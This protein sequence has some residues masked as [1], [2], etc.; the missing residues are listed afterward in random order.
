MREKSLGVGMNKREK[1]KRGFNHGM[2]GEHGK[3]LG[4]MESGIV[5]ELLD[6]REMIG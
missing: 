5:K 2:H 3:L 1:R 4:E 6:L